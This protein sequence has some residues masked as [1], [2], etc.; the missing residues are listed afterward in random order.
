[1]SSRLRE[2]AARHRSRLP[3]RRRLGVR[4][5]RCSSATSCTASWWSRLLTRCLGASRT[6]CGPCRPRSRSP[7]RV[8]RAHRGPPASS[9]ARRGSRRWCSNSSDVVTVI[10]PDTT[11]PYASPSARRVLG[12]APERARGH[13]VLRPDPPRRQDARDAVPD[14]DAA[15]ARV[16]PG[17][18]SSACATGRHL[19]LRR[20]PAH[21][22]APRPQRQRHRA[23]HPRH[24]RAQ[25]VRGA[26]LAPGVPR[27]GD[28]AR[29]PSAVPRP[30]HA[31]DRAT[32]ARQQAR[33]G[34]VHGP[35][36]LQDDQRLPGARRR[37]TSSCARS[38]N[39]SRSACARPTPPRGSVAT[40]SRSCSR[41]AATASRP[42][43]SPTA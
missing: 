2:H 9:R 42:S 38:A 43:T 41:T 35:R 1:M 30:R 26:A 24:L 21:Q 36:R 23:Q 31:R 15:T 39:G 10:D 34:P 40:S 20:D 4:G 29:E 16:T 27:L 18:S 12:F 28:L 37:A 14:V 3:S 8:R 11:V 6:R 5:S 25:G 17:S 32:G 33:R 22:P 13:E 7:S 19:R